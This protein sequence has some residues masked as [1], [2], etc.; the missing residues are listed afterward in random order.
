M[1]DLPLKAAILPVTPYQQNCSLVWCTATKKAALIDP[2]GEVER[3]KGAVV[4]FGLGDL[5]WTVVQEFAAHAPSPGVDASA[6]P[7]IQ[8]AFL[9]VPTGTPAVGYGTARAGQLGAA[10]LAGT[11]ERPEYTLAGPFSIGG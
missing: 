2:G 8:I 7:V 6:P 1:M 4:V 5:P 11:A 10:C 9:E 3:L